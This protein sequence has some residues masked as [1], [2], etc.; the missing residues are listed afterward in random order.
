MTP[1]GARSLDTATTTREGDIKRAL[2][3]VCGQLA[4]GQRRIHNAFVRGEEAGMFRL[5][6]ERAGH[7]R[8]VHPSVFCCSV[9]DQGSGMRFVALSL[10][11]K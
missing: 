11:K 1:G 5:Y 8:V 3:I 10:E 9:G 2:T 4:S 6:V 7:V